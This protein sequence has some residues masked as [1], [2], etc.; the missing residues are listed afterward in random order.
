MV[1]L[2]AS[3]NRRTKT[4]NSS[5]LYGFERLNDFFVRAR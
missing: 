4:P 1:P 5:I 3:K 2:V